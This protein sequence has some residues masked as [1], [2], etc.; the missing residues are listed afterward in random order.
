MR[1]SEELFRGVF[2][3]AGTGISVTDLDGAFLSCNPAYLTMVGYSM[4][5]LRSLSFP[6]I[7]HPEDREA[8]MIEVNRLVAEEI[9]PFE[10]VNRYVG[11]D[12]KSI[13]VHKHI[14]LLRDASGKPTNILTLVTN[15]T[16]RKRNEE[17]I[18]LL[19]REV[20]HRSKNMLS[21]VQ[22]VAKQTAARNPG[23][24]LRRFDERIRALAAS[25]DLLVKNEWKGVSLDELVRSQLA[26]FQ[27]LI[28]TRISL[29]GRPILVSGAAPQALGMALHELATNAGKYGALSNE[30]GRVD[31]DWE[32]LH[33]QGGEETFTMSW[34]E[35][36]GPTVAKPSQSGFGSMMICRIAEGSLNAEVQLDYASTGLIWRLKCAAREIGN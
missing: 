11:K 34:R 29:R 4:E 8:N 23:D 24:F 12:G 6:D 28:D 19:L 14:S 30:S 16:E 5:E 7:G 31:V 9:P 25:Q 2:E 33:G 18:D 26:H 21:L 22:A 3:F 35:S 32:I 20:N 36:G 13:W 27:D 1:R 10:I 17:Q 15:I